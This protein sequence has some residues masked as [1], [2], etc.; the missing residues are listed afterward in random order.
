MYGIRE[1]RSPSSI[2]V[3]HIAACFTDEL[4]FSARP[5]Q[6]CGYINNLHTDMLHGRCVDHAN[7]FYNIV[8]IRTG[9]ANTFF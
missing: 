4:R 9:V 3:R 2:L 8:Y 5:R 6:P 1:G 7:G